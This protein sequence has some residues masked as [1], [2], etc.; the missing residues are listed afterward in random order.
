MTFSQR[1]ISKELTR[2]SFDPRSFFSAPAPLF[3]LPTEASVSVSASSVSLRHPFFARKS[4][5]HNPFFHFFLLSLLPV[6]LV[7][8]TARLAPVRGFGSLS[9]FLGS[10]SCKSLSPLFRQRGFLFPFRS[11]QQP[12][13]GSRHFLHPPFCV[14]SQCPPADMLGRY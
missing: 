7:P 9:L 4:P 6:C 8:A 1:V 11:V 3:L 13:K 10:R 2:C 12:A 14:S 5:L